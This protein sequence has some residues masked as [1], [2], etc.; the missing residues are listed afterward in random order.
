MQITTLMGFLFM[1]VIILSSIIGMMFF[2]KKIRKIGNKNRDNANK[3]S[4]D[5]TIGIC[6]GLVVFILTFAVGKLKFSNLNLT[7]SKELITSLFLGTFS[8][9]FQV[10]I[11]LFLL[12]W[13]IYLSFKNSLRNN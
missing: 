2:F 5:L 9:L 8:L 3:I 11:I 13:V 4:K 7:S 1:S 12:S 6:S 10:S